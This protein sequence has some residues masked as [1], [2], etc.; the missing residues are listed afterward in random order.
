MTTNG[1]G[2]ARSCS[3]RIDALDAGGI[4]TRRADVGEQRNQRGHTHGIDRAGSSVQAA[5]VIAEQLLDARRGADPP[6][7][8]APQE[9][10][11]LLPVRLAERRARRLQR[12]VPAG[13]GSRAAR[14]VAVCE[15]IEVGARLRRSIT[16][17]PDLDALRRPTWDA[18][19]GRFA[20]RQSQGCRPAATAKPPRRQ[21]TTRVGLMACSSLSW[22]PAGA[23]ITA[24]ALDHRWRTRRGGP[25]GPSR[26]SAR[27]DARDRRVR[28]DRRWP[29]RRTR[30]R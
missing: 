11:Q 3:R 12:C 5:Q 20:E 1:A 30:P 7:P 4:A 13:M 15:R 25:T 16:T 24:A 2:M 21:D 6:L 14:Q 29:W 23:A 28:R 18:R 27:R 22:E 9:G 10:R 8:P 26:G 17:S 19:R